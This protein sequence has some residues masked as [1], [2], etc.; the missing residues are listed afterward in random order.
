VS[1]IGHVPVT[2]M[3]GRANYRSGHA[4]PEVMYRY[5]R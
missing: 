1:F 4:W 3:F 5:R 2:D